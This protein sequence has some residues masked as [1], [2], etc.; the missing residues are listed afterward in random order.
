VSIAWLKGGAQWIC[1][2]KGL[3]NTY[4]NHWGLV[5]KLK[6][7]KGSDTIAI[8]ESY[9]LLRAAI[10]EARTMGHLK[11]FIN[12]QTCPSFMGK[13]PAVD[14]K[15]WVVGRPIW[16]TEDIEVA[17]EKFMEKRWKDAFNVQQQN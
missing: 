2:T 10:K 13:M 11:L 7:C 1:A 4:L 9:S 8:R 16:Q 14:W 17:F 3:K 12:E 6:K 15:Q 5:T